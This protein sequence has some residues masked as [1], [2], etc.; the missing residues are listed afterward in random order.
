MKMLIYILKNV[1]AQ[2]SNMKMISP[3][4]K[5]RASHHITVLVIKTV[6]VTTFDTKVTEYL[7]S[8]WFFFRQISTF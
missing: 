8:G 1:D 6:I 3:V 4:I 7:C 5:H 2:G